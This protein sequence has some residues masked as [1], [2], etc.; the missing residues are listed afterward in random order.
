LENPEIAGV[1]YQQG[2]LAGYEVREYLLEKWG[3]QCV[4]CSRE[5]AQLQ[6]EHIKPKAKGGSNRIGNLTLAC[7]EC[8]QKKGDQDIADFLSGKPDLLKRV[9]STAPKPL[10]SASAVNSTRYAIVEM[11]KNHCNQVKCWTGGRTKFNRVNQGLPKSHSIDAACV[12]ESGAKI[13]ILVHQPLIVESKGHGTKQARRCN[14]SGFPALNKDKKPIASKTEYTH[15]EAGDMVKFRLEKDRKTVKSGIYKGRV[16][17]PTA[18]GFE[19]KL[20]GSRVS[21]KMSYLIR[22]IHRNDGYAYSF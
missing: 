10:S 5:D 3:R 12:G 19:V 1:E 11:A 13:K 18:K 20:N 2:K 7:P 21:Q 9:L 8:N 4:Y 17:T 14:A 22:F 16:K 6:I 15:C